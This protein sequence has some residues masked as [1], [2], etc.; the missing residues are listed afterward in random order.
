MRPKLIDYALATLDRNGI[1][2][3]ETLAAAGNFTLGGALTS[4]GVYTADSPRHIAFYAAGN[5]SARTFT[6][7]G[8]DRYGGAMTEAV[9]GPN[10]ETVSGSKNF[11][12]VTQVAS[13]DATAGDVEIGTVDSAETQWVPV[14]YNAKY[15]VEVDY[16][17]MVCNEEI[18]YTLDDPW[19]SLFDESTANAY[20]LVDYNFPV[21]AIRVKII[22]MSTGGTLH[23]RLISYYG[24]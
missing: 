14:D 12:T 23:F 11:A 6:I 22:D 1:A 13:D 8:T 5:E 2:A 9:T 16:T 15:N 24:G 18:Q 7:T 3:A 4:G 10:A 20:T 17:T 19:G 21:R